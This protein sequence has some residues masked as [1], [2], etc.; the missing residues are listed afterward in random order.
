MKVKKISTLLLA[1]RLGNR[2]LKLL[3]SSLFSFKSLGILKHL[4]K[5]IL[6]LTFSHQRVCCI[7]YKFSKGEMSWPRQ[8]LPQQG[9]PVQ[10]EVARRILEDASQQLHSGNPSQSLQV[11]PLSPHGRYRQL[12]PATPSLL[13]P[14]T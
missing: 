10:D 5:A 12:A 11:R 3:G 13:V 8:I 14:L 7:D 4:F 1:E 6:K 2:K 9:P